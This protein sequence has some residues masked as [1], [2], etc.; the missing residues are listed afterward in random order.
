V[1]RAIISTQSDGQN[2][3]KPLIMIVEV[4]CRESTCA[5]AHVSHYL[6]RDYPFLEAID[7]VEVRG[8]G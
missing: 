4:L 6:R 5:A 3:L 7:Y 2:V 8:G 1:K